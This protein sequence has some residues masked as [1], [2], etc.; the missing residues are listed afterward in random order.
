MLEEFE[1]RPDFE[2]RWRGFL[3]DCAILVIP[4]LSPEAAQFAAQCFAVADAFDNGQ[5]D[6]SALIEMRTKYWQFE[7]ARRDSFPATDIDGLRLV[8]SRLWV[9]A[10][11]RWWLESAGYELRWLDYAGVSAQQWF[12]LLL[13][14]FEGLV[15]GPANPA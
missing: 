6:L 1:A 7:E 5:V 9:H 11:K 8:I 14:R 10:E 2:A 4:R 3:R 13:K 12:P 15:S